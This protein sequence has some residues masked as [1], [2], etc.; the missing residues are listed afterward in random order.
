VLRRAADKCELKEAGRP[1]SFFGLEV[2][3]LMEAGRPLGEGEYR[4]SVF[5]DVS[6]GQAEKE[7]RRQ[8]AALQ[9]QNSKQKKTQFPG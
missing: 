3:V 9:Y 6:A 4:V 2:G 7:K 5:L 1:L 8:A